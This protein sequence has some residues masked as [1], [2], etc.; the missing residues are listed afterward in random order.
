[1]INGIHAHWLGGSVFKKGGVPKFLKKTLLCSFKK[2]PWLSV[3]LVKRKKSANVVCWSQLAAMPHLLSLRAH[4]CMDQ[5]QP[6]PMPRLS[7]PMSEGVL[8]PGAGMAGHI[9]LQN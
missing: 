8:S 7:R 3:L 2:K 6:C 9:S 4:L 5:G 1:M